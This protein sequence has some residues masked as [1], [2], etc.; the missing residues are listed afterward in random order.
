MGITLHFFP[1][2]LAQEEEQAA[3]GHIFDLAEETSSDLD[4]IPC[5]QELM[6]KVSNQP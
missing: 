1:S 5:S 2:T 6:K 3:T 4:Y